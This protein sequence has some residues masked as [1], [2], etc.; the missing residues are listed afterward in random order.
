MCFPQGPTETH[1]V[2]TMWMKLHHV[3]GPVAGEDEEKAEG[4]R[5]G[6]ERRPW[7]AGF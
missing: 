2:A 4:V 1:S 6:Q 3:Y 5:S 7:C